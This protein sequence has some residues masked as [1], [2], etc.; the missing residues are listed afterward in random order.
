MCVDVALICPPCGI[1]SRNS[2]A[3]STTLCSR[4]PLR[5]PQQ[6]RPIAVRSPEIYRSIGNMSLSPPQVL[7]DR[8][9]RASTPSSM[10]VFTSPRADPALYWRLSQSARPKR[11]FFALSPPSISSPGPS[12]REP[13]PRTRP[14][15][16]LAGGKWSRPF[17]AAT[18][19]STRR[20]RPCPRCPGRTS[21]SAPR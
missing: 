11:A 13:A 21:P 16:P 3:F 2:C 20:R 14:A 6:V 5:S 7:L 12:R 15:T 19:C 10:H 8:P 9:A 17:A 4:P 1:D 18:K